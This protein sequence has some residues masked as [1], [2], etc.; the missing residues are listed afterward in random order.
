MAL[1]YQKLCEKH[2]REDKPLMQCAAELELDLTAKEMAELKK[3][4]EFSATLRAE[5]WKFYKELA[6]DPNRS[7]SS[8]IGS[9]LFLADRLIE[10]GF[11]DKA[12]KIILDVAKLEGWLEDR[13]QIN[14][15]GDITQKDINS[16]REK[17]SRQAAQ[18]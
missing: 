3:D 16:L 9:L 7:K 12:A 14:L 13:T 11:E 6:Q 1:W 4:K 15:F 8:A 2:V 18:A 10:K 17:M 5:R